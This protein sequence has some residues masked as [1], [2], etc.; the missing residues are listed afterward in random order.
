MELDGRNI[1][2][3][4]RF[5][6][7][8]IKKNWKRI[9][10]KTL[11]YTY[12]YA[13]FCFMTIEYSF[14]IRIGAKPIGFFLAMMIGIALYLLFVLINHLIVRLVIPHKIL[15]IFDSLLFAMMVCVTI[16]DLWMEQ[17]DRATYFS[18]LWLI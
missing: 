17:S 5:F 6:G 12:C 16:S 10:A 3:L 13:V 8:H 1:V 14:S 18:L 11:A 4:I 7:R 9:L 15:F 2:R